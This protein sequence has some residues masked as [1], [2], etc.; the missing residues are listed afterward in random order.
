M[1]VFNPGPTK[2][3]PELSVWL[4]EAK[5]KKVYEQ[6]HRSPWFEELY[7]TTRRN[8]LKLGGLSEDYRMFLYGCA[9]EVWERSMESVVLEKL[10]ILAVGE[11]GRRWLHCAKSMRFNISEKVADYRFVEYLPDVIDPG[12]DTL[13][14]VHGETAVGLNLPADQ[15]KKVR[16]KAAESIIIIDAV[17]TFP[18]AQADYSI[19]DVIIFSSPKCFCLPSGLGVALVN[20]RA[21]ERA[22]SVSRSQSG[23]ASFRFAER[24]SEINQTPATPNVLNL[25]LLRKVSEHYL[26]LGLDKIRSDTKARENFLTESMSKIS[27]NR[28]IESPT[29][30][31]ETVLTFETGQFDAKLVKTYLERE[32]LVVSTGF[33]DLASR[34]IRVANFPSYRFEDFEKLVRGLEQGFKSRF[35]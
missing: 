11:F 4:D 34:V 35:S 13:C 15:L 16:E 33:G 25:W 27:F 7:E 31:S 23:Y 28:L 5:E 29:H 14:L 30:R 8:L 24:F 22:R 12:C 10:F 26:A 32:G 21:L 20:D 18:V 9:S 6:H 19:A 3:H 2:T 1:I 17:S